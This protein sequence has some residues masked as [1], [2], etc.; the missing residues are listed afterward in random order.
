MK[1]TVPE[2]F[3]SFRCL[4]DKCSDS[5]CIGWEIDIDD[6]TL[7]KYADLN[8]D[9][10]RE[11]A[12]KTQ[13][14]YFDTDK[15]GRCAF[16]DGEGLC[17][18]I[19]ALGDGYLC[20]ICREHPRYYGVGSDGIEGGLGL[21]CE[22]AAKL[23]LSLKK[24]PKLVT[25]N[26]QVRYEAEDEYGDFSDS[27]RELLYEAIYSSD[28][29]CIIS[30]LEEYANTADGMCFDIASGIADKVAVIP[31]IIAIPCE[32]N[33]IKL[34]KK[35]VKYF[36][37]CE[38]LDE[39]FGNR[40]S[41]ISESDY[42]YLSSLIKENEIAFRNLLFYFTHRYVREC[43]EDMT[44]GARILFSLMA[45]LTII[46]LSSGYTCEERIVRCAVDF[47]KNIEYSTENVN[48]ILEKICEILQES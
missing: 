9:L 41:A 46:L 28:I 13:H 19:S 21:S 15:N 40:I 39:S 18:I 44:L 10:G 27:W 24:K 38:M 17:R 47:S 31:K 16:L 42:E 22:A 37:E 5:C 23:I 48:E 45:S 32:E 34:T 2:Y 1:I 33:A 20:D 14:G 4:A 26:R 3:T 29:D 6:H 11:I 43:V 25:D 30:L 35:A 7:A 8:S 36:G 12:K